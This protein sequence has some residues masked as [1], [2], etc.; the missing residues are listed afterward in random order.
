ML[1]DITFLLLLGYDVVLVFLANHISIFAVQFANLHIPRI[2][3]GGSL[4]MKY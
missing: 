2:W 4:D 3:V 1:L